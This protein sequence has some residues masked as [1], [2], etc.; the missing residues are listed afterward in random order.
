MKARLLLL[1]AAIMLVACKPKEI[2]VTQTETRNISDTL[3]HF[4][5]TR[6]SIY[7]HDSIYIVRETRSD[8]IRETQYVYRYKFRERQAKDSVRVVHK[9]D[10]VLIIEPDLRAVQLAQAQAKAQKQTAQKWRLYFFA[11]LVGI[12]LAA[13]LYLRRKLK[14]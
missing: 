14:H 11:L 8:T 9:T 10:T 6:D 4:S 2:V 12:I 1:L 7:L 5:D 13:G 3:R